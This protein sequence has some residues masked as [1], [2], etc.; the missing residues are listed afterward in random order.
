VEPE[1]TS[2]SPGSLGCEEGFMF[3][4]K[5][6]KGIKVKVGDSEFSLDMAA[7]HSANAFLPVDL[8][9]LFVKRQPQNIR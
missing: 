9:V 2:E 5:F 6:V 8:A 4:R 7:W 3:A 1:S